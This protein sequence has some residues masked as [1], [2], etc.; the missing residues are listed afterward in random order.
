MVADLLATAHAILK[1]LAT[2]TLSVLVGGIG[3]MGY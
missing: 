1:N 2:T 3:G